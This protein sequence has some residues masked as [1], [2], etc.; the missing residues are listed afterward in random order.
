MTPQ[1]AAAIIDWRDENDE[2]ST[3]GAEEST[4]QRLNP[5]YR[6][7]NAPF[8]SVDE[9]RLV[10]GM[11]LDILAGEDSNRNGILDP[12][13]DDLDTSAP[14]DNRDGRLDPGLWEYVT[15]YSKESLLRADGTAKIS[16]G[17]QGR[18]ARHLQIRAR[19]RCI[20]DRE[21]S[22]QLHQCL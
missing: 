19:F 4:Y 18:Q 15:V 3:D 16:I 2:V 8:E 17:A 10:F 7:K 12:N 5:A 11:T 14:W 1:L 13:E 6:C 9:L 22:L 20:G 21:L